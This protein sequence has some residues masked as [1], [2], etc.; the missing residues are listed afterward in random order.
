MDKIQHI[1]IGEVDTIELGVRG[2]PKPSFKWKR[3]NTV[4]SPNSRLTVLDDG[5]LKINKVK[6]SDKGNYTCTVGH[7]STEESVKI[8]VYAVGK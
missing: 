2:F 3:G 5:S 6:R 4:L 1:N 7:G 8:E